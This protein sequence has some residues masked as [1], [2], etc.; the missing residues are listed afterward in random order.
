M[1]KNDNVLLKAVSEGILS[2]LI[3]V[4]AI[5]GS[6]GTHAHRQ[7]IA[8][9]L[10][11]LYAELKGIK[12]APEAEGEGIDPDP[13]Q[14]QDSGIIANIAQPPVTIPKKK[15]KAAPK[16]KATKKKN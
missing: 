14:I 3:K 1:M 4:R 10:N 12:E 8:D 2:A 13:P 6:G 16:K 5:V 7:E 11:Q 9:E 15:A